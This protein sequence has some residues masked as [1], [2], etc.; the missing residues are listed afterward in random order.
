MRQWKVWTFE[1]VGISSKATRTASTAGAPQISS[2]ELP[3]GHHLSALRRRLLPPFSCVFACTP[4]SSAAV[5]SATLDTRSLC[6]KPRP[7]TNKQESA[8][9][10]ACRHIHVHTSN[11]I[12]TLKQ[13]HRPSDGQ[14]ASYAELLV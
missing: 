1:R 14:K 9:A 5:Y 8:F 12:I 6:A 2:Y 11:N 7:R 3:S 4:N 10:K 13:N